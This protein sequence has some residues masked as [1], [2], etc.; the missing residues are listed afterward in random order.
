MYIC[1]CLLGVVFHKFSELQHGFEM[2]K[3]QI[4]I[5]GKI[6]RCRYRSMTCQ[7][8]TMNSQPEAL[9]GVTS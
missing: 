7:A 2:I 4:R 3:I 1:I 8:Q 5:L 9:T 6:I